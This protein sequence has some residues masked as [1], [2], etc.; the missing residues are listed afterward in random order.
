MSPEPVADQ[1]W[2]DSWEEFKQTLPHQEEPYSKRSWGNSN[3]SLCSFPGKLKPAIAHHLVDIFVPEGGT[4]LDPFSGVG[5]IPFEA[6][7]Q[8]YTPYA[9]DLSPH[10]LVVT[11]A[12]LQLTSAT[13][14]GDV[15]SSL[16]GYIEA[17]TPDE[18]AYETVREFGLNGDIEEYYHE[19][20]L[21]EVLLARE[22]FLSQPLSELTPS[23]L[24][25]MASL[26]HILHGNRPYALSRRSHPITPYAPSGDFEYRPLI[27]R[28]EDKVE[29]SL[30]CDIPFSFQEGDAFQTDAL[31]W[32]PVEVD[33]L[34][35]VITSPPFYD[36]T[37]FYS[38]N[39]L[40]LWFAG[41]E[42]SDFDSK[43]SEFVDKRQKESF[44]VYQPLL[45]Q[46]RERLN[47]DG[48]MVFHLGK[49][50]QCDMAE[51]IRRVAEP[52][53]EN[54]DIL[55]ESVVHLEK[56]GVEDKGSTTNHMYLVLY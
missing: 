4:M 13:Q 34:D 50:D 54:Y 41:W 12:K 33:D 22:F 15:I 17:N 23:E 35:A 38:Q 55:D 3:H 47:E 51:E 40:R 10:A 36:S 28:V 21:E 46:C 30:N 49:S 1:Q 25:V 26:L 44:E 29:R 27:P 24:L 32:W 8:G 48:V 19:D 14:T 2:A 31:K 6:S 11:K 39:W 45:R 43:P 37:R 42:P 18:S 20:T 7:L 5:T 52:W 16:E 9:F 53:F 56:H